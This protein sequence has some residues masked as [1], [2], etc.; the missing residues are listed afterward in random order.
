MLKGTAMIIAMAV[1]QSVPA[2][3]EAKPNSPWSGCQ[4]E[5]KSSVLSG[6]IARMGL[7]R[8]YRPN[9][10]TKARLK[11]KDAKRNIIFAPIASLNPLHVTSS[12]SRYFRSFNTFCLSVLGKGKLVPT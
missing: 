5:E 6:L 1:T 10:M 12:P 11:I 4:R 8:R 7:A 3:K 2:I 9:A